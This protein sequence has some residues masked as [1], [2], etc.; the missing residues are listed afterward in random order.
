MPLINFAELR[1]LV[2]E[3]DSLDRASTLGSDVLSARRREDLHYT[4]GV[5]V[6]IRDPHQARARALD[7]LAADALGRRERSSAET[8]RPS[9]P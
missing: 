9:A 7:L 5:W 2:T 1:R 4:L 8:V 3:L 6:G